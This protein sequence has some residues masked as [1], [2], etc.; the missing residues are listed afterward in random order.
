MNSSMP[1]GPNQNSSILDRDPL[2]ISPLKFLFLIHFPYQTE[3]TYACIFIYYFSNLLGLQKKRLQFDLSLA[4]YQLVFLGKCP[5]Q[6][7]L[8]FLWHL[9]CVPQKTLT[10]SSLDGHYCDLFPSSPKVGIQDWSTL[11]G[12][13]HPAYEGETITEL[14]TRVSQ[15]VTK[16]ISYHLFKKLNVQ[17]SVRVAQKVST[18]RTD[19]SVHFQIAFENPRRHNLKK[20][21]ALAA[22]CRD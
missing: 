16:Q 8:A 14:R 5:S 19:Q 20:Q 7:K 13:S 21:S 3:L 22:T 1:N 2:I 15:Q 18:S 9:S 12:L 6:L 4:T 11:T 17:M 10:L